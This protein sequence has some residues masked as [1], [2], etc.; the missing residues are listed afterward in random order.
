MATH[1]LIKVKYESISEEGK[2]EKNVDLYLM[3]SETFT[4]T[5]AR[6][7]QEMEKSLGGEFEILSITREHISELL[8]DETGEKWFKAKIIITTLNE[9]NGK[10]KEHTEVIYVQDSTLNGCRLKLELLLRETVENARIGRIEETRVL[11]YF[12]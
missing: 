2:T 5:E 4:E 1:F 6:I 9:K 12:S 7:Y 11:E 10:E 8:P 3:Q